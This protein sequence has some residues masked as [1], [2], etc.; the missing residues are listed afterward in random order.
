MPYKPNFSS[1][2]KKT[3]T[4]LG[5]IGAGIS[6]NPSQPS[7]INS[8]PFQMGKLDETGPQRQGSD[9]AADPYNLKSLQ[10]NKSS[11]LPMYSS[12][13]QKENKFSQLGSNILSMNPASMTANQNS[14]SPYDS[15]SKRMN[16]PISRTEQV[17]NEMGSSSQHSERSSGMP[18]GQG[19]MLLA[20]S[21][22]SPYYSN[23]G[24]N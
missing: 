22:S 23:V 9:Q 3:T 20:Q 17:R 8:R 16:L 24:T 18:I 14:S 2:G 11:Q 1:T 13:N 10:T 5:Q 6:S 15:G 21:K 12:P 7:Q 19:N 4:F